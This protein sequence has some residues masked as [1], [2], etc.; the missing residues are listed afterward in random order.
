MP[1]RR[2]LHR[3]AGVHRRRV[4]R[5]GAG[6]QPACSSTQ[7]CITQSNAPTCVTAQTK[8]DSTPTPAAS[9]TTSRCRARRRARGRRVRP[10]ARQPARPVQRRRRVVGHDPRR[11]DR[12]A[13]Q[14]HRGRH[15]RR[16]RGRVALR[17]RQR[18]L[19]R[20]LR[21]RHQGAAQ[22]PLRSRRN[23]EA[24][25][26]RAGRRR[27]LEGPDRG[28]A[29]HRR[30]PHR[31][32]RLVRARR[33]RRHGDDHLRGRDDRH[34][35]PRDRLVVGLVVGAQGDRP[36]RTSSPA[37]SR[38]SCRATRRSPT[39]GAGPTRRRRASTATSRLC[40]RSDS[41]AA[42]LLVSTTQ[43]ALRARTCRRSSRDERAA[44]V[45][46]LAPSRLRASPG[47]CSRSRSAETSAS[48]SSFVTKPASRSARM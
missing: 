27:R 1:L 17:H 7:A 10:A 39:G 29:V 16:R 24:R 48:S 23:V 31:R 15:R 46:H 41:A 2:G 25:A 22:V 35:A 44:L 3:D 40:R 11:R 20:E 14:R 9:V 37:S 6:V 33:R 8:G 43:R 18:R 13:R 4:H 38:T 34:A 36:A 45:G 47:R 12:I 32:R 21:R 19:A 30:R 42:R 5:H 26:R 28:R